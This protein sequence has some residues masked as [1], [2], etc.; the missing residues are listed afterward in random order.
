M[1]KCSQFEEEIASEV[2]AASDI[3]GIPVNVF[4]IADDEE[5]E[6]C[7]VNPTNDQF[8]GRIEYHPDIDRFLLFYPDYP[9]AEQMGRVRF[10]IAHEL[11]HYFLPLH[12]EKLQQGEFHN[13]Q[14]GFV[15]ERAMEREADRFA[16]FLLMPEKPIS[17]RFRDRGFL[18]LDELIRIAKDEC[19]VSRESLAIRY[20]DLAQEI[21]AAVVSVGNEVLYCASSDDAIYARC[22]LKRGD[23]WDTKITPSRDSPIAEGKVSSQAVF[24]ETYLESQ[25]WIE[26]T[27]LGY[28]NRVLSIVSVEST[29]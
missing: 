6:L 22:K 16:A 25:A 9:L 8:S 1:I 18:S 28:G 17:R 10:S 14:A 19:L 23:K 7:P 12:R 27:D 11:G 5:I 3:G 24:P 20:A 2:L 13:S 26:S 29:E 4:Q 15:C 21:C